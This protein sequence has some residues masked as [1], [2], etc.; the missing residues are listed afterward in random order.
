[1]MLLKAQHA[2]KERVAANDTRKTKKKKDGRGANSTKRKRPE[3]KSDSD[4]TTA[5]EAHVE[6]SAQKKK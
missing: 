4:T 1:M 5:M 2:L 6:R 3:V